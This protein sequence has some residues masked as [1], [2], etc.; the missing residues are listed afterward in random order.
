MLAGGA[1]IVLHGQGDKALET[2]FKQ[3]AKGNES[4]LAVRIGYEEKLARRLNA[5]ADLSLTASRFEP[6]GLT[7]MYAMRYGALP[8]T[9]AVGGLADTVVDPES[10]DSGESDATGFLFEDET[11]EA[12]STCV[13]RATRWFKRDKWRALQRSAMKRDFG[14]KR[15][16]GHYMNVYGQCTRPRFAALPPTPGAIAP[17]QS[18]SALA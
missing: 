5:A 16:A 10:C 6:C 13:E 15:S 8:V 11:P 18:I 1:Q 12:M 4:R 17:L 9:R 14:W 3:A 7:T 2:A